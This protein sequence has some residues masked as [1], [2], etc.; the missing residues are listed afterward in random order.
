MQ[1]ALKMKP[2][3]VTLG[4]FLVWKFGYLSEILLR[5]SKNQAFVHTYELFFFLLLLGMCFLLQKKVKKMRTLFLACISFVSGYFLSLVCIFLTWITNSDQISDVFF[6]VNK[7]FG[8]QD[9]LLYYLAIPIPTLGWLLT[10][11]AFF[12]L[13]IGPEKVTGSSI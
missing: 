1:I 10:P 12:F 7:S 3:L 4:L 13:K 8:L 2:L 5:F 11:A 9:S 6:W